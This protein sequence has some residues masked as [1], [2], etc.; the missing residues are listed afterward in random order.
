MGDQIFM[1]LSSRVDIEKED[2]ILLQNTGVQLSSNA[3]TYPRIMRSSAT[4]L[5]KPQNPQ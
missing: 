3:A 2:I 1:P 5:Q 4:L